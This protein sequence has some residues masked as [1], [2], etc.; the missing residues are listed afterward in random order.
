MSAFEPW[1]DA[2][3]A[4][5]IAALAVLALGSRARGEAHRWGLAVGAALLI[6]ALGWRASSAPQTP[7]PESA[8]LALGEAPQFAGVLVRRAAPRLVAGGDAPFAPLRAAAL[9]AL[10]AAACAVAASAAPRV[11]GSVALALAA[12]FATSPAATIALESP[13]PAWLAATLLGAAATVAGAG[14]AGA[15]GAAILGAAAVAVDVRALAFAWFPAA[16]ALDAG[17]TRRG[18]A[19]AL[20]IAGLMMLAAYP[21]FRAWASIPGDMSPFEAAP[22]LAEQVLSAVE[23]VLALL[24]ILLP[25]AG[26]LGWALAQR[27]S[28]ALWPLAATAAAALLAVADAD[29]A[30]CGAWF[31]AA[32]VPVLV[33]GAEGLR[34]R[35]GGGRALLA[36]ACGFAIAGADLRGAAASLEADALRRETLAWVQRPMPRPSVIFAGR[37]SAWFAAATREAST[38][39]VEPAGDDALF[40]ARS[41]AEALRRGDAVLVRDDQD[42]FVFTGPEN[43]AIALRRLG[44][45]LDEQPRRGG[46]VELH[47]RK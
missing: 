20:A 15:A 44:Y 43:M 10:A 28:D 33:R 34:A 18:G 23:H 41:V 35:L 40:P 30:A 22:P 2:V 6:A 45:E 26:L 14:I 4:L 24:P 17:C 38:W 19:S 12:A 25:A 29:R 46:L 42:A 36:A 5:A 47:R 31:L 9:A 7:S 3:A 13:D 11:G 39:R 37:E 27:R 32:A 21:A 1:R 16:I 8:A